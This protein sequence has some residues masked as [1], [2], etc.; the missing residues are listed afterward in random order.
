MAFI[1]DRYLSVLAC[2]VGCSAAANMLPGMVS[3]PPMTLCWISAW[4]LGGCLSLRKCRFYRYLSCSYARCPGFSAAFYHGVN[5]RSMVLGIVQ[6]EWA[7][8]LIK[9][10]RQIYCL[11][12]GSLYVLSWV[13]FGTVY[14]ARQ[15][16]WQFLICESASGGCILL[17]SGLWSYISICLFCGNIFIHRL[18]AV[19]AAITVWRIVFKWPLWWLW[20]SAGVGRWSLS[21]WELLASVNASHFFFFFQLLLI[22][23]VPQGPPGRCAGPLPAPPSCGMGGTVT[24]PRR[25]LS[26]RWQLP[27]EPWLSF[28]CFQYFPFSH[29]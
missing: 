26:W 18:V 2:C 22:L 10:N 1:K 12:S 29:I 20:S 3:R 27:F 5:R 24:Q 25:P 19:P 4:M 14:F 6:G 13:L 23:P 15:W 28:L 8:N 16:H 17:F 21:L 9:A 11:V 7:L